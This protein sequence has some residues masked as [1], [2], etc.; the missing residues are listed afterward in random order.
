ML[1]L[2]TYNFIEE[3]QIIIVCVRMF[4]VA[5]ENQSKM[6]SILAEGIQKGFMGC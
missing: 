6:G 2:K 3:I 5:K 1:P 4:K